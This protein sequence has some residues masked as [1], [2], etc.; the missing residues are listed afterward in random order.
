M[1][2]LECLSGTFTWFGWP[3]WFLVLQASIH[4]GRLLPNRQRGYHTF[5]NS[6]TNILDATAAASAHTNTHHSNND[7]TTIAS[8]ASADDFTTTKS[9]AGYQRHQ[10]AKWKFRRRKPVRTARAVFGTCCGWCCGRKWWLAVVGSDILTWRQ[11]SWILVRWLIDRFE[12]CTYSRPLYPWLTSKT[13]SLCRIWPFKLKLNKF[14]H[15]Q[16]VCRTSVHCAFRRYW[17]IDGSRTICACHIQSI[18]SSSSSEILT[19]RF[20]QRYCHF[21]TRRSRTKIKIRD[22]SVYAAARNNTAQRTFARYVEL[23]SADFMLLNWCNPFDIGRRASVVGWGTTYYGG[24]E[25]TVQRQAELP[26]W[27][28]EDCNRAYYQPITDN[29]LC[30]GYSEGGVDAC[31][32]DSGE[33]SQAIQR[34]FFF[35]LLLLLPFYVS[36]IWKWFIRKTGGPLMMRVDTRW[37]QIGIVSFGNKC[38]EPGYPGVYTRVSEYLDWIQESTKN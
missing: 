7:Q 26:I 17:F 20:L 35:F 3:A 37:I 30:A 34:F 12:I 21:G 28:N 18:R 4:S 13:V 8:C 22:S 5:D 24:K 36:S 15:F 1:R 33:K 38:G 23:I 10:R 16:Q 25:S 19:C 11:T 31:Q 32:G 2:R 6:T 14:A 29:F 9:I 27:R